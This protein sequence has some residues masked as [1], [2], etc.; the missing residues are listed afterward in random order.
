MTARFRAVIPMSHDPSSTKRDDATARVLARG[1]EAGAI[2]RA[3]DWSATPLGP[4]AGWSQALGSTAALVL[5]N[6]SGMLLWWGPD[7]IQI[8]NDA[9]RP[10]LG[11]KHPRAMGQAFRDCWAEVFHVLG[12]MAERPLRGGPASTSDDLP[13][14]INRK[15]HREET[16]FRLAYSPVPDETVQPTGIGGV[17]ATVTEITEE[18]YGARQLHTLRELGTRAAAEGQTTEQ[19]CQVAAA[20]L[21]ENPWDV[22]FAL[23]Y[24]LEE[25]GHHARLAA[26]ARFD[27]Q[28][29][30]AQ[31]GSTIDLQAA[32]EAPPWR[33]PLAEAIGARQIVAVE[34]LSSC[35]FE[36]PTSPWSDRPRSALILPL[37]SPERPGAYGAL[38]FGVS[39]HRLLDAGYCAFFELCAGQVVTA[40][41]NAHALEEQRRR[42][43]ALAEI[44]RAKTA[45]FSNV[46]HEFRTPLTLMLGPLQDA[47]GSGDRTLR[48][49]SLGAVHRNTLRLLKLVNALLEFSR[50]EAGRA[51]L[52]LQPTD[53]GA[54][55]RDL[56]SAFHSTIERAGL[57]YEVDCPPL[58]EPVRVDRDMWER[59]VLNLLSNAFKFTL[60]GMI[61]V[62]QQLVGREVLLE[63]SD[64]GVGIPEAQLPRLFE[65]FHRIVGG[66]ART[67]EGSGIG[68]ALVRDT[69]ALHGG[70]VEV[71]S[72]VGEGTTFTVTLPLGPVAAA[73]EPIEAADVA[74]SPRGAEPFVLEAARWLPD[75]TEAEPAADAGGAPPTS[76]CVLVAD[77]NADMRDYLVRLLR[78]HWRVEATAD[79][80]AALA[81]ARQAKPDLIVTDVMMPKLD[82]FGLLQAVRADGK[83]A[84]VPIIML[85]ARAGEEAHVG[86]LQAGADDYL[87]KP[88][89][90]R[91]L[92]ARVR[93]HLEGARAT[94][95]VEEQ[96]QQLRD[97]TVEAE[98]ARALAESANRSKDE[99]LAMLGHELRNPLSPILTALQVMRMRGAD[100]R[101]Q[102]LIE[103]QMGHVMRLVDDLLDIS[104][105]TRGKIEL[106]RSRAELSQ[107]VVHGLEIA[108]PLLE[109][110]RQK[111]DLDVDGDGFPLD[112]DPDRMAQVVAN[113]LTNAAKYS[114]RGTTIHLSAERDGQRVRLRVRDEGI[115]IDPEMLG[116]V[117]D[118]FYQEPQ[119]LD[120]SKGGLGLGLAIVRSLVELHG[121]TV[122][123]HSEGPGQGSEFVVELPLASTIELLE[124]ESPRQAA[125]PIVAQSAEQSGGKR[126]LIV[127]DN[128]DAAESIGDLLRDLGNE[129]ETA[130]DGPAA[131]RIAKVFKPQVC[132][133]DIGLPAMD[134]YE[135]ARRLRESQ[136]LASGARLIAVTGYGQDADRERSRQAGFDSHLVKPVNLDVLNHAV[137]N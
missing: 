37:A 63:V 57:R 102:A 32:P 39:P 108:S 5:H 51:Q 44:D 110:R 71:K 90:A 93:V 105:I 115:G 116:R 79:G 128:E 100:S 26:S 67:H 48:G 20:T 11:D 27:E 76:A 66:E 98:R 15:V 69:V 91:E 9:Y 72:R 112:A 131:L 45:F 52:S 88:F 13:L 31:T 62:R 2:A 124:V 107:V 75:D 106:R 129:I 121:G 24:L 82:G 10:V 65:R 54:F 12:P 53:L 96:A 14:L 132:L 89:S 101:E 46:S 30:L 40:L 18:A 41:R 50:A 68:L 8:Y 35:P 58:P 123:A 28:A 19:A 56:A 111:V 136:D 119:S 126:I 80:A 85:S 33:W 73:D 135:L 117:F 42:A 74:A 7:Q 22:P 118:V 83:L 16:H 122:E 70:K 84:E 17:L 3:V 87:V 95:K 109:Q 81:R 43:E 137:V 60:S 120:R 34:D 61:R 99:F 94:R 86:G 133:V 36:L 38:V 1:G 134:G 92:V 23:L 104:R 55:T 103:R 127:D 113:L 49:D 130:Y 59:I 64:T 97:A 6:D 21:A 29:L 77:D 125:S 47:L 78:P 4:V 114:E 25:D